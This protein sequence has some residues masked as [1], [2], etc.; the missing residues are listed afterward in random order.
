MCTYQRGSRS[1]GW[2]MSFKV[3]NKG[4]LLKVV[5]NNCMDDMMCNGSY[6]SEKSDVH[7]LNYFCHSCKLTIHILIKEYK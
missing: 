7:V 2:V 3:V 6:D 5:C 4:D 1:G